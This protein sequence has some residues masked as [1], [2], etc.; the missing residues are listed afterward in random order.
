[1]KKVL[2]FG[3]TENPGGVESVIMNYYRNINRDIMQFDFLCNCESVA[4]EREI[5]KLGGKIYKIIARKKNFLKFRKELKDFLLANAA[6]YSAIWV[7]VCSLVNIDYLIYAKKYGIARRIIHCH[8]ADNDAGF[9]KGIIHKV[10]RDKLSSIATDFWSCSEDASPWFF[11]ESI[12]QSKSYRVIVNAINIEKYKNNE[13][14]RNE[15]RRQ[16][17]L[18]EKVVVGHVG[19]FHFQKNHMFLVNVFEELSKRDNRY[20]LLL[21]GQGELEPQI[22]NS[23]KNKQLVERVTFAGVRDDVENLYQMMDIFVLPSVFEGLGIVAVEAQASLLPC[24]LADTIPKCV[25]VNDN[26]EFLSLSQDI[27]KWADMIEKMLEKSTIAFTNKLENSEYNI[28]AQARSIER[29]LFEE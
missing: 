7:N 12:L 5:E 3:M 4:Y 8:N 18:E 2:V 1:M 28:V 25:K 27:K 21:V 22:R 16:F 19:R 9:L 23:I 13:L 15:F 20:H 24:L 26:V 29:I 17:G 10:N 14:I 11:D 6:Q